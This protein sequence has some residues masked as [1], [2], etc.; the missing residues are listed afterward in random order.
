M[1]PK[2]STTPE[3]EPRG[4]HMHERPSRRVPRRR[5]ARLVL[6]AAQAR[7]LRTMAAAGDEASLRGISWMTM[8]ALR[9][10]GL[11]ELGPG[12]RGRITRAGRTALCELAHAE[13]AP[14]PTETPAPDCKA[15]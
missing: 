1:Q 12:R 2:E 11:C 6:T 14:D 15:S 9:A 8:R 10:L 3:I 7:A 4:A 13:A 5:L